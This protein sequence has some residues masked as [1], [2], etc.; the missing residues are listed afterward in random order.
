VNSIE[1]IVRIAAYGFVLCLCSVRA[2]NELWAPTGSGARSGNMARAYLG[3]RVS[4]D[5]GSEQARPVTVAVAMTTACVFCKAS[6]PF[7]R[8]LLA[9]AGTSV[10]YIA[11]MPEEAPR[12]KAYLEGDLGLN[13]RLVTDKLVGVE[14][15][16]TP[17]LLVLDHDG[18]VTNAWVGLLPPS[19]EAEVVAALAKAT[20]K[21][22]AGSGVEN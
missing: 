15:K 7:Y 21:R 22:G 16:S 5:N 1:K 2:Y 19:G 20:S 18:I 11:L 3:K 4:I 17:T 6:A 8:K 14:I 10:N 12:A 13:F 9:Q